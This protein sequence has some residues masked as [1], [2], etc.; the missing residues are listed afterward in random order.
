MN[1]LCNSTT[2]K[3]LENISS[4]PLTLTYSIDSE[5]KDKLCIIEVIE[6]IEVYLYTAITRK[7]WK[8]KT[9]L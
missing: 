2:G 8:R 5:I 7:L 1:Q 4:V 6:T 3:S 9:T